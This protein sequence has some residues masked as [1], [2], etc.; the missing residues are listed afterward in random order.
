MAVYGECVHSSGAAGSDLHGPGL[1]PGLPVMT[2]ILPLQIE[3]CIHCTSSRGPAVTV[4][5]QCSN[6]HLHEMHLVLCRK[7]CFTLYT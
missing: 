3:A 6:V 4:S 2:C 1:R 5:A 7:L